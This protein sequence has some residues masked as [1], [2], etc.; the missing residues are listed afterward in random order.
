MA[1][2][3]CIVRTLHR[4]IRFDSQQVRERI[5]LRVGELAAETVGVQECLPLIL[6]HLPEVSEG[7]GNQTPAVDGKSAKLLHGAPDLLT[8]RYGK[9][10]QHTLLCLGRKIVEAWLA[11]QRMLLLSQRQVAVT[12][13]PLAKMLLVR[14]R[15]WTRLSCGG[16]C[17]QSTF[18][19]SL[20]CRLG[21]DHRCEGRK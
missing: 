21:R 10:L 8:L 4:E 13:H 3:L 11:L 2:V 18:G 19:L 15:A 12:I 5:A 20:S 16:A 6:R 14:L 7:S 1:E 17:A 9:V